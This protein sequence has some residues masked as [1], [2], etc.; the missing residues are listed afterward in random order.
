VHRQNSANPVINCV[1]PV[2]LGLGSNQLW[3]QDS[4]LGLLMVAARLVADGY[5][6]CWNYFPTWTV[7]RFT[8]L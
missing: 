4:A 2:P 1:T 6:L 7:S 3:L 8:L 5:F